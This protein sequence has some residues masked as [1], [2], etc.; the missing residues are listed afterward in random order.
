MSENKITPIRAYIENANDDSIGGF[1]IPLPTTKEALLPWLEAIEAAGFDEERITILGVRSSVP[2]LEDILQELLDDSIAFDE[3]NYLATKVS[4]ITGWREELFAAALEAGEHTGSLYDLINLTEN[5][6]RFDLQ[7]AFNESQY[8][9]FLL[10]LDKDNT[11]ELFDR[12]EQFGDSDEKAL[13]Q[14][15]LRLERKTWFTHN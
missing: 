5:I 3:L 14:Y 11:S 12:L 13:A 1:T 10:D 4:E 6:D 2:G 15:I 8:G 7:P 9:E